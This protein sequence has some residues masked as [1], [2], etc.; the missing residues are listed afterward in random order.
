MIKECNYDAV[1]CRNL[2]SLITTQPSAALPSTRPLSSSLVWSTAKTLWQAKVWKCSQSWEQTL[3][4]DL[5]KCREGREVG[6]FESDVTWTLRPNAGNCLQLRTKGCENKTTIWLIKLLSN[7]KKTTT[8]FYWAVSY[9][10]TWEEKPVETSAPWTEAT[11]FKGNIHI[12]L[13][14]W[15][16]VLLF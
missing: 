1:H 2:V 10:V 12:F 5:R 14:T 11:E 16:H 9:S 13:T 7:F 15:T 3:Y 6:N 4:V 8:A